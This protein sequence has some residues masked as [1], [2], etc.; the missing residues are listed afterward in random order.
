MEPKILQRP[1]KIYVTS[2]TCLHIVTVQLSPDSLGTSKKLYSEKGNTSLFTE[3]KF[4]AS[5]HDIRSSAT[6]FNLQHTRLVLK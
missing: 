5:S 1:A 3:E 2:A 4:Q 6:K